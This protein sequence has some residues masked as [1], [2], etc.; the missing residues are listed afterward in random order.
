[1]R[2]FPAFVFLAPLLFQADPVAAARK[3]L[4][5]GYSVVRVEPGILLALTGEES[6]ADP[7]LQSIADTVRHALTHLDTVHKDAGRLQ[8]KT[9][10]CLPAAERSAMPCCAAEVGA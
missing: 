2:L 8:K 1:M 7:L 9:G 6:K 10:C 5:P 4:G 3:D